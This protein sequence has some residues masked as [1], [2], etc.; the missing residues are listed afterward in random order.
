M[1]TTFA[2]YPRVIGV[3]HPGPYSDFLHRLQRGLILHMQ[4]SKY[5]LVQTDE[6]NLRHFMGSDFFLIKGALYFIV[7]LKV[8][9]IITFFKSLLR[10]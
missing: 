6:Y 10:K 7:T 1:D 5:I 9:F 4:I 8:L 2:V 3:S